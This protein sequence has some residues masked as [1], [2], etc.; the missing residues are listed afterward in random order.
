MTIFQRRFFRL[1]FWA[2]TFCDAYLTSDKVSHRAGCD[3][4]KA[5]TLF[6]FGHG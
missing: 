6:I 1:A 5:R 3:S 4:F 2:K